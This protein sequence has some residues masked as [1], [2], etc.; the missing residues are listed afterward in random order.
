MENVQISFVVLF[1]FDQVGNISSPERNSYLPILPDDNANIFAVS[2]LLLY[3]NFS[4]LIFSSIVMT[5]FYMPPKRLCLK[6]K[7]L[8]DGKVALLTKKEYASAVHFW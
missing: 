7:R 6:H 8:S 2:L 1:D 3:N 4:F 5:I